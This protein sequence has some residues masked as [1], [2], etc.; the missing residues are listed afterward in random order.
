[1]SC[2]F[3]RLNRGMTGEGDTTVRDKAL[4]PL[5]QSIGYDVVFHVS[6]NIATS[7]A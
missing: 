1:M 6:V 3:Q 2:R 5:K 4:L 7:R